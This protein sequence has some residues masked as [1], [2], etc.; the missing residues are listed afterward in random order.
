MDLLLTRTK[1]AM[2]LIGLKCSSLIETLSQTRK[3]AMKIYTKPLITIC[4]KR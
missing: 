1:A 2:Q 4:L 3:M